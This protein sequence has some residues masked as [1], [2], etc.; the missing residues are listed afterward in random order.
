VP[1]D[2]LAG[3]EL[4]DFVGAAMKV[5]VAVCELSAESVGFALDFS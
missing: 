2:F 3:Y 1:Y 4:G 5:L